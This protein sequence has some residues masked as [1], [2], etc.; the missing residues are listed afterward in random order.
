MHFEVIARPVSF[1]TGREGF[2]PAIAAIATASF[3]SRL[4]EVG[5]GIGGQTVNDPA[6]DLESGSGTTIAQRLRI[7]AVDGGMVEVIS[8]IV[9]FH[10]EFEFS[11]LHAHAQLPVGEH[12]WLVLNAGGGS[13]G[14]GFGE[15]GL[16]VML[17]GD[18]RAGSLFLSATLGGVHMFEATFDQADGVNLNSV[19]YVGP[20]AGIGAEWRF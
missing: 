20:M 5:L 4:F 16:R 19:G 3:D 9:L 14:M 6:F 2:I 12:S 17:D 15:I 18:G 1:A 8:Y 7:G 11:D 13:I 10:S